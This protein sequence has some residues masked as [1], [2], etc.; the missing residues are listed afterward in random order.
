M[1]KVTLFLPLLL[2]IFLFVCAPAVQAVEGSEVPFSYEI[3]EN[4][5][6]VT[7]VDCY[8]CDET[9]LIIPEEIDGYPVTSIGEYAFNL[10]NYTSV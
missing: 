5:H 6:T 7:I 10:C 9:E 4:N 2:I 3:D 8:S 1:R